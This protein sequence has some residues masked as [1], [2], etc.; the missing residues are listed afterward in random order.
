MEVACLRTHSS[1]K[2]S[3]LHEAW[4]QPGCAHTHSPRAH[5]NLECLQAWC[6]PGG[7]YQGIQHQGPRNGLEQGRHH[8]VFLVKKPY[9]AITCPA[10][11]MLCTQC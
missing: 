8:M 10:N 5:S 2:N 7:L 9:T 4:P 6:I 1:S 3:P 11:T